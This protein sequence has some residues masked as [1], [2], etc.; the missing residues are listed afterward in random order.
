[1]SE[2]D[3]ERKPLAAVHA[4]YYST[5]NCEAAT[6]LTYQFVKAEAERL[7]VR[8]RRLGRGKRRIVIDAADFDLKIEMDRE[9]EPN[10]TPADGAEALR[11]RLGLVVRK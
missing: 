11:A 8:V 2:N 6:G 9:N 10:P 4:R 1:M 5:Q 7:G 3:C